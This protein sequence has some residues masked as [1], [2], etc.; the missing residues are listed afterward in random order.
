MG[1]MASEADLDFFI[2]QKLNVMFRGLHGVGKTS[3][4]ID[5]FERNGIRYRYFSAPTM[6]PWVDFI[7]VP[8]PVYDEEMMMDMLRL[9]I[10]EQFVKGE[11]DAL[12][13]DEVNR[14]KAKVRNAIM[15]LTQFHTINGNKFNSV[16]MIWAAINPEETEDADLS[17]DVEVM[18]P[19]QKDRFDVFVDVP[20]E[21]SKMWFE[22][23]YGT[24]GIGA[25]EWWH[26]LED[27]QKLAVSP[28]R[29][30]KALKM[31]MAGG[32]MRF[33]IP[34]DDINLTSLRTRIDTG[35]L[36]QKLE[37]LLKQG[38]EER[39]RFFNNINNTTDTINMI[40][41]RTDFVEAFLPYL[42]RDL[43]SE[44]IVEDNGANMETIIMD[45]DAKTIVPI[46]ASMLA[47]KQVVRPLRARI[48]EYAEARKLDLTSA[49]SF[50][51]G[52]DQ[53]LK[54]VGGSQNDRFIALHAVLQNYNS[55][56]DL[57]TYELAV[58]FLAKMINV[59][60]EESLRD[61]RKPYYQVSTH[62][63]NRMDDSCKNLYDMGIM[64]VFHKISATTL[65]SMG[66]DRLRFAQTILEFYL[67]ERPTKKS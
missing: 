54:S 45:G 13:F 65:A 39:Q 5:A 18:D 2:Q 43:I 62:L 67:S 64:D 6:D 51:E 4:M 37:H 1:K 14:A 42:Q 66:D 38:D 3:V 30:D 41:T 25:V 11:Y 9:I 24:A 19:A 33:T 27:K 26:K 48:K 21:P 7:G 35:S 52:V 44:K 28:R 20:Y 22:K 12:I 46:L 58:E 31:F 53:A 63:M 56:A 15:E 59:C 55:E 57:E 50:R 23:Q 32:D 36:D 47:S 29:L 34:E 10:P 49:I 8:K 61:T 60:K 17:F 16:Q 40:L